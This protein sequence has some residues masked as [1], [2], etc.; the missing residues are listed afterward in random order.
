MHMSEVYIN[1]SWTVMSYEQMINT[2]NKILLL[3]EKQMLKDMEWLSC[4]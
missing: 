4:K 2:Q 3:Q 1:F